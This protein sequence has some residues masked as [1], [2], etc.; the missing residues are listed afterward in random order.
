MESTHRARARSLTAASSAGSALHQEESGRS[1]KFTFR[2]V[3][4]FMERKKRKAYLI[5]SYYLSLCWSVPRAILASPS[6]TW[7]LEL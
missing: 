7:G 4:K 2:A 5:P 6:E 1:L 3:W